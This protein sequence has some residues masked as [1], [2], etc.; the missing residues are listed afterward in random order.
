VTQQD[1]ARLIRKLIFAKNSQ[2][3]THFCRCV[4]EMAQD[5][6]QRG[7]RE[8][9]HAIRNALYNGYVRSRFELSRQTQPEGSPFVCYEPA[10]T[11]ENR[12]AALRIAQ[13]AKRPMRVRQILKYIEGSTVVAKDV[14]EYDRGTEKWVRVESECMP[15]T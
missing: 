5:F 12:D 1:A 2:D 9:A 11:V 8:N 10:Y 3:L 4:E 7:E 6:E 13:D 15:L 14:L